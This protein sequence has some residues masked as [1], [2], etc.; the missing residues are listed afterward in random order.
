MNMQEFMSYFPHHVFRML[1]L[2]GQARKAEMLREYD[3]KLNKK[4]RYDAYF[5]VNGFENFETDRDCKLEHLTNINAFFV[6]IDGRK[7][8]KEIESI[9]QL[10]DPTFIVETM[11]GYHFY[12]LLDEPIFKEDNKEEWESALKRW[13]LIEQTIVTTLNG[14]PV[15]KD[16]TRILRVPDT[17]YWKK[18]ENKP[19]TIKL[20]YAMPANRYSLDTI[21]EK[22]PKPIQDPKNS[23]EH[24]RSKS[25]RNDFFNRVEDKYP[26]EQRDSFK[27]LITGLSD[28]IPQG[29]SR[30]QALL[31]TASLARRVGWSEEKAFQTIS[32]TGWHGMM[33]EKGGEREIRMTIKS[34]YKGGYVFS[35]QN[36]IIDHNASDIERSKLRDTYTAVMKQK[37]ETDKVRFSTYEEEIFAR[38]PNLKKNEAGILFDYVGGI[39]KMLS[40]Q[41]ETKMILDSLMEDMLWGFRTTKHVND[42][43][44]CLVT[45]VPFIVLTDDDNIINMKNGLYHINERKMTPHT[46][47]YV[48]LIQFPIDYDPNATCPTWDAAIAAWVAGEEAQEKKQVLQEFAGYCITNDMS[49]AKALFLIG[50]GGNGKSTYADTIS[51]MIGSEATSRISLESIYTQFGMAG[52]M[53]KRLNIVEEIS[54]NYFQ[55]HK[56]KAIISG[57]EQTVDMKYRSQF[58]F[59]PEAKFIFAVNQMP[60]VDDASSGMERRILAVNFNNNFRINPNTEL[61][62]GKGLLAKELSGIFNWALEGL[63][64]L[65]RKRNFTQTRERIEIIQ[66]YREENSS[67]AGFV[68]DCTIPREGHVISIPHLYEIYK[69]YCFKDGRKAK[70]SIS[71]S[72]DLKM[73]ATKTETLTFVPRRT[74]KDAAK[75]EG[76][77][78]RMEW[79]RNT[80]STYINEQHEK[81]F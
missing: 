48:S 78:V 41:E 16:A 31:V 5:T 77:D 70:S 8:P 74:G 32:A 28:T 1:D 47:Q 25:E 69:D 34:A 80:I 26:I 33:K 79:D 6:D 51:M 58:K 21:E 10:L 68:A 14:D 22:F 36:E 60:R 17:L 23:V 71:F 40:K 81:D 7:D 62:F 66:E 67:V 64:E 55:G 49:Y 27:R 61:R 39:Y 52:L 44:T 2:T 42:K 76:L 65:K 63:Y 46:P 3:D 75:V 54:A 72:K 37:K 11:R 53:G 43:L 56:I 9:K 24:A 59:K 38:H 18:M 30:N 50:D 45:L 12:W 20:I 35:P 19:F 57:E 4:D 73:Y 13:E 29:A 15:V